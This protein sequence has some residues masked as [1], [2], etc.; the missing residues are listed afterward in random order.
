MPIESITEG[1]A[2]RGAGH[3]E[4][5]LALAWL[6]AALI[7]VYLPVLRLL[8]G[9][10]NEDEDMGY[11]F[12]VPLVAGYMIWEKRSQLAGI[13]W[14]S[15]KWGLVLMIYGGI[16]M[17]IGHLGVEL[18]LSRT[19]F[20]ISLV[21]CVLYVCGWKVVK[22]ISFP[23]GLL[24]LMVPIPAIIYNQITF[25][26]QLFASSV[27]EKVLFLLG[28]PVL[29]EGNVLELPSQKLSVVEACSGIRS[30]LA[31]TFLSLTYAGLFDPKRWMRVALLA[32]T[33]PIAILSNATRVTLTGIFSEVNPELAS[34][35]F[36][37]MEGVVMYGIS[38][39]LLFFAHQAINTAWRKFGTR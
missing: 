28:I 25:P 7:L 31:L 33:I 24:V 10:W 32:V 16:Q 1:Q 13:E 39:V 35:I 37:T 22:T 17:L 4:Q 9:Q 34:G 19:A 6:G 38:L 27:A 20:V 14:V 11:G 18:F 8:V 12:F 3:K 29:R 5:W 36:H 2:A 21:G 23:L 26:L 15:N 30:L